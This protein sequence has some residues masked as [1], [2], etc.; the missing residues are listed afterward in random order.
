MVRHQRR[1]SSGGV[2]SHW[3]TLLPFCKAVSMSING[4]MSMQ[5]QINI[6]N[7]QYIKSDYSALLISLLLLLFLP[8]YAVLPMIWTV[9]RYFHIS[10]LTSIY[11][12]YIYILLLATFWQHSLAWEKM[13]FTWLSMRD[14]FS[15]TPS[16]GKPCEMHSSDWSIIWLF[17]LTGKPECNCWVLCCGYW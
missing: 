7:M 13:H 14:G 10:W 15:N 6:R 4:F 12:I 3:R 16:H 5:P 8:C 17:C 1:R 2:I 11:S 9:G